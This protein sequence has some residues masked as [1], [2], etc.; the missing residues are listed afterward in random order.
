M[1]QLIGT[2]ANQ[3]PLNGLLGRA[4]FQ[5]VITPDTGGT[6]VTAVGVSGN[7]L[8]SDGTGWVSLPGGGGAW[9]KITANTN[10][11]SKKQYIT[12]TTSGTF[13]VT[14]PLG[15]V[16]G[17]YV[18]F[19]DAGNW[20]T[21]NLTVARNGS[22]IEALSSDLVLDVKGLMV[23]MIYDGS[24]WQVTSNIGPQGPI[25]PIGVT[26]AAGLAGTPTLNIVTTTTQTALAYNQYVLINVALST[27]T[28]PASPTTGDIVWATPGNG[29]ITNILARNGSN[30]MGIE[31]DMTMNNA[32]GNYQMRYINAT[33]GWRI[34]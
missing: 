33:L 16:A 1:G 21:N 17:D 14:L 20:A 3:V 31:E 32:N 27:L 26:G 9:T 15:P 7:V 11:A 2:G 5:D 23:Q 10:A 18:Y 6:G 34:M 19:M 30:I 4:A 12:D 28:L 8:T 24:T 29:L 25:G 13:T 22:T